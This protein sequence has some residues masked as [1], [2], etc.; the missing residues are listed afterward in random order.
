MTQVVSDVMG[1][2]VN[3]IHPALGDSHLPPAPVSGGSM[4]TASVLPAVKQ[5]AQNALKNL[6]RAALADKQSPLHGLAEEVSRRPT[7]MS[8]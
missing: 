2:P 1:I 3:R 5:A 7:A 6:V 4:T 8:F